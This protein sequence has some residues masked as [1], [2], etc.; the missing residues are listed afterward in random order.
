MVPD[1]DI[2]PTNTRGSSIATW[3]R[4]VPRSRPGVIKKGVNSRSGKAARPTR[5]Y[6]TRYGAIN[7]SVDTDMFLKPSTAIFRH[8]NRRG[9]AVTLDRFG[10]AR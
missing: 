6:D 7:R 3:W 4:C 9:G 1:M 5:D 2:C 10:V 8:A